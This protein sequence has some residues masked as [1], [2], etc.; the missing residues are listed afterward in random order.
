MSTPSGWA[1]GYPVV[2][3]Y[4]PAWHAFQSPAHIAAVCALSGVAWDVGPETPLRIAEIG[5]GTGLT[6]NVLAAGNPRAEVLG[7]DYNPAHIAEA[8]SFAAAAGLRNVRFAE[9]D[10]AELDGAAL[11][12]LP[13]FDL[14][15]V[16]GLWSWVGDAV[17][18]GVLRLL[19]RRLVPGGVVLVTYN[20][21]PGAAG[22]LGL[23]RLARGA[24]LGAGST[25]EGLAAAGRLV[26]G[27]VEAEARHLLPNSWRAMLLGEISG[28]RPGYLLHEFLTEHWR[29]CFFA[30][31]AEALAGA[32]CDFVGSATLD[33]NFPAM[34]LTPPQQKLWEAAP[35]TAARQLLIDLCVP[36]AFRRDVFQ[37]GIRRIPHEAATAALTLAAVSHAP[38]ERKLATQAGEATLPPHLLLPM[39]RALAERPHRIAE[40]Q[41]LPGC[42]SVSAAEALAMLVGSG[43]A[44]LLWHAPGDTAALAAAQ[45]TARRF[46]AVTAARLAPHGIG[47]GRMAL[48]SPLLGGGMAVDPLE[49][50]VAA[51]VATPPTGEGDAADLPGLLRRLLPPGAEPPPEL[52]ADVTEKVSAILVDRLPAWQALGIV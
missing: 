51:L 32:R 36:R 10:L 18:D 11:D 47:H 6:A 40:L 28:A 50:A 9:I 5:C 25:E 3:P 48:A 17:R 19:R 24:L 26:R 15:T 22:A 35:D 42:G 45:A 49:V 41:A 23:A 2:Q 30:D 20:A 46:N 33:E 37:R 13:E 4:P 14:V 39:Q 34:T 44:Q 8:R 27:L 31:V 38:G 12:A 16:H 52:M 1:R 29:P 43:I 21:M 7:I